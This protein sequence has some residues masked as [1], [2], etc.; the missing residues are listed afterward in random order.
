ML[1]LIAGQGALPGVLTET[2]DSRPLVASLDGF[3]PDTVA[4]ELNF[5][6]EHLGSFLNRLK[7]HNISE[8]CFAGAIRRPPIDPSQIDAAT[9]PLV[10]RMMEALQSGDDAAL[11][12]VIQIFEDA[13]FSVKAVHELVPSLLPRVGSPTKRQPNRDW[14]EE[15]M[16]ASDTIK[17]LGRADIGQSCVVDQGQVLVVEGSFGT[18]WMLESLARRPDEGGG[19]FYKAP[20]PGQDRRID[21]P[22]IGPETVA[23]VAQ[24]KLDG[25]AIEHG[26]VIML[27][28]NDTIAAADEAGLF[29]W[30]RKSG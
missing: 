15:A 18:D 14:D 17:A 26:G 4:S 12:T 30:V 21:L 1:A 2:L 10:P 25:I 29:L 22:V 16:R 3:P 24:A 23:R 6:I 20:K 13:G 8:V 28:Q 5:R 11:R 19:L 7:K 9:M 27:D